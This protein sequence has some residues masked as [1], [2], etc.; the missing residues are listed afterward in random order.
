M[1][2]AQPAANVSAI[3]PPE[4]PLWS[5][6]CGA[7]IVAASVYY[8]SLAPGV[9]WGDFGEAQL[10]VLT[11]QLQDYRELARS[12][13]TYFATASGIS[14]LLRSDPI[15][16]A[17][18]VSAI[19]G[20]ITIANFTA[21]LSLLIHGR[22]ALVGGMCLLMFSHTL[23]Q[24]S[25]G[26]EVITF[27]M[28][29]LSLELLCTI[30][31]LTRGRF[32]WIACAAMANGL[33]WSTHNFALLIWPAY[34]MTTVM[35]RRW[36]SG[37]NWKHFFIIASMWLMGVTPLILSVFSRLDDMEGLGGALQ[38]VFVG[39]YGDS[40]FNLRLT[41]S[42][43]FRVVAY[44]VLNFPTP[45]LLLL[46][47]GLW[48]F[49]K[50]KPKPMVWFL[51]TAACAYFVFAA[52]YDVPDQ[53][54]FLTHSHMFFALFVAIGLDH[55]AGPNR[56]T[57]FKASA[58]FLCCL[59]PIF[60]A[61]TPVLGERYLGSW[62]KFPER[63][64]PYREPYKWFL[65]PWRSG[66]HGADR[67]AREALESLPQGAILL[68]DSTAGRPIDV[69]QGSQ[70]LRLDVI[71]PM[72]RFERPWQRSFELDERKTDQLVEEGLLFSTGTRN[73]KDFGHWLAG[74]HYQLEPFGHLFKIVHASPKSAPP[75]EASDSPTAP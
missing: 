36:V 2:D 14:R 32:V 50:T 63:V 6:W 68:I 57:L 72:Q 73:P 19:A 52:R 53:Y 62:V 3:Q 61:A 59:G 41:T 31:F 11:C 39:V 16:T 67:Y 24:M 10:R 48:R 20:A 55:F 4:W 33:G 26:A 69:I 71:I 15:Q 58:I 46:P 66:Y 44:H 60:Y 65:Q 17:N 70:G 21:L 13:V 75:I 27:S 25:A 47:I 56:S 1:T 29:F 12:H 34:I 43:I 45:L 37:L 9:L 38:S 49:A 74:D 7:F 22:V 30:R 18:L 64:L 8:C 40:V 28:M 5:I 35:D 42:M 54:T 23:W 51:T